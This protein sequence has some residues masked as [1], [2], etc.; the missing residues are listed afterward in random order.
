[1]R[2]KEFG[3]DFHYSSDYE[4]RSKATDKRHDLNNMDYLYFSG[5]VALRNILINGINQFNW[6]KIYVPT[7]Y[8]HEVYDFIKDLH[9]ELEFYQ[10]NPLNN[11]LPDHIEDS[12]LY[13]ILLVDYFGVSSPDFD[14]LKDII[15]I[16]DLTHNL[17]LIGSSK[18]DYIFGSL[19]K[20]LPIPVGGFVKSKIKLPE[21]PC[22]LFAEDVAMEKFTGMFLKKKYLEGNFSEK[23]I[24]RDLLISAEHSFENIETNSAL[25]FIVKEYL[26][27]LDISKIIECKKNNIFIMKNTIKETPK[28]ELLTGN[29][30][31]EYSLILKFTDTEEREKLKKYLIT[32]NIYPMVLW[33]NQFSE[34]D[35]R[36]QNS[37]L[38][39]H[40][41]FRYTTA[42]MKYIAN[43]INQFSSNA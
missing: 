9:I 23:E 12:N 28:F 32:H 11:T 13:V 29:S 43:F 35:I 14:H 3:S 41:D 2:N 16:K 37:L 38:F 40:I 25:P 27:E 6:K 5:R 20:I 15:T 36:L 33:P 18:A 30:G 4:F 17:S 24:F 8:C 26:L 21:I 42:D 34:D 19:R 22:T 7:Y 1:M 39:I 31:L 10:C